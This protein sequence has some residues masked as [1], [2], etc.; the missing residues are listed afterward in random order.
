[1]KNTIYNQYTRIASTF[2]GTL[3]ESVF[4]QKGLLTPEEFVLAG[5]TLVAKCPTWEWAA[6]DDGKVDT[7]MPKEKQFLVTKKVPCPKRISD[8]G[9]KTVNEVELFPSNE[10]DSEAIDNIV[11]MIDEPTTI[12]EEQPVDLEELENDT[13]NIF[14]AMSDDLSDKMRRYDLSITYDYYH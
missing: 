3:K 8:L 11:H 6:A 13:N 5:D 9:S 14:Q 7:K 2:M 1:M 10:H 12:Q 4:L